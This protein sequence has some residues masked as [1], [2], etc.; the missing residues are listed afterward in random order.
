[1]I[2]ITPSPTADTRTC[3]ASEITKN[4]LL[5]SSLA[6]IQ[7]VGKGLGFFASKLTEAAAQHDFDKI[8]NIDWF[9]ANFQTN[10][11]DKSWWDNH[12]HINRH[13]LASEDGIPS[14]VNLLDVL[15]Y[16]AD[17]VMAGRARAGEGFYA[18]DI[19]PE[20][21]YEAFQNTVALLDEQIVIVAEEDEE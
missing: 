20:V 12:R 14:D 18:P 15:E 16:I 21:L 11:E 8:S 6:H 2:E 13:H 7:D 1:M 9:H 5:F 10:F 19:D 17:C 3:N 4:A